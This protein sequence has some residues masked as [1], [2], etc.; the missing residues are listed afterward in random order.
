MSKDKPTD[1]AW[2]WSQ[3]YLTQTLE[4]DL[5]SGGRV[6]QLKIARLDGKE[7]ICNWDVLQRIKNDVLGTHALA[8]EFYPPDNLVV[9]ETNLRHLWVFPESWFSE[10]SLPL[11]PR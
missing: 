6:T 10:A 2:D 4:R 5:P 7:I 9:N 8:I 1:P 3:T 11:K